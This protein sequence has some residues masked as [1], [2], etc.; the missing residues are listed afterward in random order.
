[1]GFKHDNALPVSIYKI[2][3]WWLSRSWYNNHRGIAAFSP[4]ALNSSG[5]WWKNSILN[6]GSRI[7]DCAQ[8]SGKRKLLCDWDNHDRAVQLFRCSQPG[9]EEFQDVSPHAKRRW[10][11]RFGYRF[12]C[13]AKGDSAS[14]M[15][16]N[17]RRIRSMKRVLSIGL[18]VLISIGLAILLIMHLI[19]PLVGGLVF[20]IALVL[21]GT[22][23]SGFRGNGK[24]KWVAGKDVNLSMSSCT[25]VAKNI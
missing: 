21:I 19:H 8:G 25:K 6:S 13:T 23:S 7:Y 1:M 4:I 11:L 10:S 15:A 3:E 22:S 17:L 16:L 18:L 2:V 24:F 9:S 12:R 5:T 20:A 14:A